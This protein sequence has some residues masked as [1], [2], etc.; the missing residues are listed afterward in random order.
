[1]GRPTLVPVCRLFPL[2]EIR[3]QGSSANAASRMEAGLAGVVVRRGIVMSDQ[4]GSARDGSWLRLMTLATAVGG[5][6]ND[7]P[8]VLTIQPSASSHPQDLAV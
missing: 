4:P 2:G 5:G 3:D 7:H 6:R 1:M 8:L